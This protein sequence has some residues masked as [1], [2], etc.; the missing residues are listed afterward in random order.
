MPTNRQERN[1][2]VAKP[3]LKQRYQTEIVPTLREE[4][5][6]PNVMAVPRVEKVVLN[7]GI[8]EA[9]HYGVIG[10]TSSS[11]ASSVWHFPA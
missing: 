3:R 9:I 7:I 5:G 1:G 2:K 8:G 11:T 10:C 4:F 6:Y